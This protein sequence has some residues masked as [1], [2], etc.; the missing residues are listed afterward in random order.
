MVYGSTMEEDSAKL[1]AVLPANYSA[2]K[3]IQ[4]AI[5][6]VKGYNRTA[7]SRLPSPWRKKF[8]SFLTDND[9]F[10]YMDNRLVNPQPMRQMIMCSLHYGHPGCDAML[11][12]IGDI[13][14][15]RMNRETIDRARLCE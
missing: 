5:S 6:I 14:V 3:L 11:A 7:V 8:Q 1:S 9:D 10:L 4:R 15:P 12:M 13:W 2:D